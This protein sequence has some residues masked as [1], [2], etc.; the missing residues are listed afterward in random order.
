M[1]TVL[2][3]SC[4]QLVVNV[5]HNRVS[6]GAEHRTRA[7]AVSTVGQA[8]IV[9]T[10][11]LVAL[12]RPQM[13][14]ALLVIPSSAALNIA[15]LACN[16]EI[17]APPTTT[18]ERLWRFMGT[19]FIA[20]IENP[21]PKLANSVPE[22][23]GATHALFQRYFPLPFVLCLLCPRGR[24]YVRAC[25]D[26]HAGATL[27]SA[28]H[29]QAPVEQVILDQLV[30]MEAI[31]SI[32][33]AWP[34]LLWKQFLFANDPD[35]VDPT[36][37]NSYSVMVTIVLHSSVLNEAFRSGHFDTVLR[38]LVDPILQSDQNSTRPQLPSFFSEM[39]ATAIN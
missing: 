24:E 13:S 36:D 32:P 2:T 11:N 21:E 30:L 12:S 37:P 35:S 19:V 20:A 28:H 29:S 15:R 26:T 33:N 9:P 7:S 23:S 27:L 5:L 39:L 6:H 8:T 18:L 14:T 17:H 25:S 1:S 22:R 31:K 4:A 3:G 34:H 10:I 38:S 16:A